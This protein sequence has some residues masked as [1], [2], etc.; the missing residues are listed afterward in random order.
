MGKFDHISG[1]E[2]DVGNIDKNREKYDVSN[3]ECE[4]IFFNMPLVVCAVPNHSLQEQRDV[5]LGRTDAGRG[6]FVVFVLRGN[7]I[8]VISARDMT[9]RELGVYREKLK[10]NSKM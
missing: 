6:L 10:K 4:E 7:C 8:R 5:G 9:D 3:A 1:F 2:W